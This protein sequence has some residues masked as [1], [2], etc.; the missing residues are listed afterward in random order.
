MWNT[1]RPFARIGLPQAF[2]CRGAPHFTRRGKSLKIPT[3]KQRSDNMRAIKATSNATTEKRLRGLLI[4]NCIRGWKV[5]ESSVLGTPDFFFDKER[6]AIF[7]DGCFWHGC[8]KCGHV[9]KTNRG[10]WVKKL[11]RNK[12]RDKQ[13]QA[14]LRRRG[15]RVVRLWECELRSRPL[16]CLTRVLAAISNRLG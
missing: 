5:R 2:D 7:V 8:P 11:E 4:R 10:Y 14:V 9:P 3:T 16:S 15:I 6:V 13:I 12:R 1:T